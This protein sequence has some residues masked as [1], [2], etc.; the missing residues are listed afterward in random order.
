ME[1]TEDQ[2]KELESVLKKHPT[3]ISFNELWK[4]L[5]LFNDKVDL[6]RA[7]RYFTQ[8]AKIYKRDELYYYVNAEEGFDKPIAEQQSNQ[9]EQKK[10]E[11]FSMPAK[12]EQVKE[13]PPAASASPISH[14]VI[15]PMG[16]TRKTVG[17]GSVLLAAYK[18]RDKVPYLTLDDFLLFT[19]GTTKGVM[20]TILSR[21][22]KDRYLIKD[23]TN[24][25]NILYKWSGVYRYPFKEVKSTDEN[26]LAI[27]IDDFMKLKFPPEKEEVEEETESVVDQIQQTGEPI[28]NLVK[29]VKTELQIPNKT[30]RSLLISN[31]LDKVV[32]SF[33][34][35]LKGLQELQEAFS[36][37]D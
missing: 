11:Y 26:I 34:E 1:M 31:A 27:T 24:R 19:P 6:S 3:G 28:T 2:E 15:L 25:R 23:D 12:I 30:S 8:L 16:S 10:T 33:G 5:R 4:E 21:L 35:V 20:Y 36:T 13:T 7:I 37:T 29:L 32:V 17:A 9:I 18:L 22:E 14:P